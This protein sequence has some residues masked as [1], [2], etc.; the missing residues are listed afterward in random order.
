M[1]ETRNY[2]A[3][4]RR[5]LEYNCTSAASCRQ[6]GVLPRKVD[7]RGRLCGQ[8]AGRAE[9]A[10]A[11]L[12]S[13]KCD[14]QLPAADRPMPVSLKGPVVRLPLLFLHCQP[15]RVVRFVRSVGRATLR[16]RIAEKQTSSHMETSLTPQAFASSNLNRSLADRRDAG[17]LQTS[18]QQAHFVIV[19][20]SKVMVSRELGVKLR[21]IDAPELERLGYGPSAEGTIQHA[22][23]GRRHGQTCHHVMPAP[24]PLMAQ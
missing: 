19:S 22:Q 3:V 15:A 9:L 21:W 6:A 17:F 1:Q 23:Q 7:L 4:A 14:T 10:Q 18:F 20:G 8:W 5:V 16:V 13:C 12:C 11:Y 24:C 2:H